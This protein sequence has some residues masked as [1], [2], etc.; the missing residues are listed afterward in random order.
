MTHLYTRKNDKLTGL[1]PKFGIEHHTVKTGALPTSFDLRIVTNYVPPILDQG[2]LGSCVDNEMSNAC[3]FCIGKELDVGLEYQPSR[4]FL[5]WNARKEDNLPYNEDTGSSLLGCLKG[6]TTKGVC[7]ETSWPYIISKYNVCPPTSAFS[8]AETHAKNFSYLQIPQNL[9]SIKQAL[10]AGYPIVIGI[11]VY[12]SFE[13]QQVAETG[14]VPI[15]DTE[16]EVLLGGH[17]TS[18]WSFNDSTQTFAMMNSWGTDWGLKGYCNIPYN[19][20]LDPTL[21][22]SLFQIRY[23]K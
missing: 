4:L 23:F 8:I 2:E 5:Y 9:I 17:S 3:R 10:F 18:L 21:C 11:S 16:T 12:S 14:N 6:I 7:P 20:I 19:Y 13:S 22:D 1:E 15:P